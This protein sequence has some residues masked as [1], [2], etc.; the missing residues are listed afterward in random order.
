MCLNLLNKCGDSS[1]G[2]ASDWRSEGRVFDPRSPQFISFLR[3][4]VWIYIIFTLRFAI[5]LWIWIY[6]RLM[7]AINLWNLRFPSQVCNWSLNLNLYKILRFAIN[8]WNLR[9]PFS[10]GVISFSFIVS[11]VCNWS[12][13]FTFFI[14]RCI[15]RF[16]SLFLRYGHYC[17]AENS[18]STLYCKGNFILT[19]TFMSNI[20]FATTF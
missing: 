9:F 15:F 8:L 2:R 4:D 18:N 10:G 13:N 20:G 14:L 1:V 7:F 17:E 16:H 12:M 5:D 3:F 6:I 19:P 11:Q